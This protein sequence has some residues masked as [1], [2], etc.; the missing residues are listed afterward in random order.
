ME[1]ADALQMIRVTGKLPTGRMFR[2]D[3]GEWEWGGGRIETKSSNMVVFL[4]DDTEGGGK[5]DEGKGFWG[6]MI[7]FRTY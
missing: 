6:W 4:W 7:L 2:N 5:G 1:A 3:G